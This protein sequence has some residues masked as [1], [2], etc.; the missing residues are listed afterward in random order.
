VL[1]TAALTAAA[2]ALLLTACGGSDT[3]TAAPQPSSA[4]SAT[5][6]ETP[7]A[8]ATPAYRL[9][10]KDEL[11]DALLGI[12]DFPTGFSQD[13]QPQEDTGKTFCDYKEPE[14][15][16][17]RVRRDF[18][19]GG[20]MDVQAGVVILRQYKD[21]AAARRAF[22]AMAKELETCRDDT[23]EGAAAKHS[24]MSAPKVGD[25][26]IG[27]RTEV[28]G[29]TALANY[30]V[31]GPVLVNAGT[32]SYLSSDADE[33]AELLTKQVGAYMAAAKS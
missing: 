8:P 3:P 9:L 10:S 25:A 21:A 14:K 19:K 1:K 6:A 20:G 12:Q 7:A 15:A 23:L 16:K 24:V 30:S 29:A 17:V 33:A 28:E 13:E 31:V 11:E 2:A 27:V 32:V 22:D 4:T 5:A 26:S 18:T